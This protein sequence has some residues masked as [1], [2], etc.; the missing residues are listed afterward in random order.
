M[1]LIERPTHRPVV[2]SQQSTGRLTQS[3]Q[4]AYKKPGHV[5]EPSMISPRTELIRFRD[6][7]ERDGVVLE[8]AMGIRRMS[9]GRGGV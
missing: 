6:S 5:K 4:A 8:S 3:V 1:G 2:D 9:D 7:D